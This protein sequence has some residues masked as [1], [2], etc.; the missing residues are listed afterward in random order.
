MKTVMIVE[1]DAVTMA[2]LEKFL[3]DKKLKVQTATDGLDALEKI[4][5]SAPDLV[6]LDVMMPKMDGYGFIREVRK[7]PKLR[8]L[9]VVVLTAREMLRDTFV[10]EGVKDFVT[11]PYDPEEL[12]KI[13][14]KYL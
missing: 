8:N 12:Y 5:R 6:L 14:K 13:V 4:R 11:K 3:T 2:L 10:Q 7:D 9:S 1:D